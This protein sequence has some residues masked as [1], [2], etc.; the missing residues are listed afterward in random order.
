MTEIN[1]EFTKREKSI[2]L[3]TASVA[4]IVGVWIGVWSVPTAALDVPTDT[5][6]YGGEVDRDLLYQPV[7]T[8]LPIMSLLVPGLAVLYVRWLWTEQDADTLEQVTADD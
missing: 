5:S 2:A 8:G 4:L 6:Y 1:L 3:L 7:P